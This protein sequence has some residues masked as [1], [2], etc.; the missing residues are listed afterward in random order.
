MVY[1]F[2]SLLSNR[3]NRSSSAIIKAPAIM[4][5]RLRVCFSFLNQT[6]LNGYKVINPF[7]LQLLYLGETGFDQ[8]FGGDGVSAFT[9]DSASSSVF[10]ARDVLLCLDNIPVVWARSFCRADAHAWHKVLNCGTRPLGEILFDDAFPLSRSAFEYARLSP[11]TPLAGYDGGAV[12]ARRSAFSLEG[13]HL[14]LIEAF[15]PALCTFITD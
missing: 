13:N 6:L 3:S 11:N 15:L 7:S 12:A 5:W 2:V 14:G 1:S 4:S 10:F 8:L 9:V